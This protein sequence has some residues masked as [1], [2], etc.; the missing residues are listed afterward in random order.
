[1]KKLIFSLLFIAQ[2]IPVQAQLL[3]LQSKDS[4]NG[5]PLKQF[6]TTAWLK[7]SGF[8]DMVGIPNESSMHLPSIPTDRDSVSRDPQY[9]ADLYQ[10]RIIFASEFQ[11]KKIGEI[12]SYIETDFFGNGG[13]GLRLRHAYVRFLNFRIGQTWSGFTD[14]EAWPNITDFDGPATG[15]W[16]RSAQI[17][18]FVRPNKNQ[19]ILFA[20]ETPS[21]DYN[22]YLSYD[23]L[24]QP[25]LQTVPDFVT[26]YEIRWPLG[27]IQVAAVARAIEYKSN[28]NEIKYIF[29][30]GF[31]TSGSQK[32]GQ[33][34][35]IWQAAGGI[36][37]ARYLVSFGGGGWDAIPDQN[38]DLQ[39]IPI[40]GGYLGYQY[41]WGKRDP[42]QLDKSQFS[43][44]LVYGYVHLKNPLEVP[45]PSLLTG[46][47]ASANIYWHLVGP[48]NFAVEGIYG[49][50]TDEFETSGSN[51]RIQ[52]VM[53][54]NF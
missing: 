24:V 39:A 36:G 21:L 46:S 44:T 18:Y 3:K 34:K 7:F 53:E 9:H 2:L 10:T 41:F 17:T 4:L 1:M 30:G 48:L 20:I 50:R 16:V 35:L 38:G 6:Y 42:Y 15:A 13:G 40:Y 28:N 47:Y 27:H 12:I 52:F 19:D 37:I 22:R 45:Y 5:K 43:S 8:V 33:N 29:G 49:Y 11:T 25:A 23:T 51:L 31:N 14:E 54:Y 26:H 32:F